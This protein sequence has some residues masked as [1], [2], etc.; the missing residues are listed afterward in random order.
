[1]TDW[2]HAP[3]PRFEDRFSVD[4]WLDNGEVRRV[5]R[6]GNGSPRI[7]PGT[8]VFEDCTQPWQNMLCDEGRIQAWRPLPVDKYVDK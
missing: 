1:M 3:L 2:I 8:V 5:R 6:I 4:A 7:T